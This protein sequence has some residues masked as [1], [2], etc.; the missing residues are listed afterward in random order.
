[1]MEERACMI[2]AFLAL[3]GCVACTTG[4]APVK[5][6]PRPGQWV[7]VQT[8]PK[9]ELGENTFSPHRHLEAGARLRRRRELLQLPCRHD[10]GRTEHGLARHARGGVE[11]TLR[12]SGEVGSA[13]DRSATCPLT[14]D[15]IFAGAT[16][17]SD[18]KTKSACTSD[19]AAVRN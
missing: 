15:A 7:L 3:A 10:V 8:P 2:L 5:Q 17:W 18:T 11:F 19:Q 4:R 12:S 13:R 6:G 9:G 1:M 14:I 16:R